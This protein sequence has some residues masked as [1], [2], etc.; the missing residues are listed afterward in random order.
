METGDLLFLFGWVLS[1]VVY[2]FHSSAIPSKKQ[3]LLILTHDEKKEM[4]E[5]EAAND[6]SNI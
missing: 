5:T 4:V 3:G 1:Q 2:A 6:I